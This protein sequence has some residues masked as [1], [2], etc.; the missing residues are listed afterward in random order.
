MVTIGFAF[1]AGSFNAHTIVNGTT[2]GVDVQ[3]AGPALPD[4]YEYGFHKTG[5]PR[6]PGHEGA[7]LGRAGSQLA[8]G[9]TPLPRDHRSRL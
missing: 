7:A 1:Y 4:S 8:A 5:L 9:A 2:Q 3:T 6:C